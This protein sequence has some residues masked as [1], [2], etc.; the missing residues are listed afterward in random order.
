MKT[1]KEYC[2]SE[3][4]IESIGIVDGQLVFDYN[5]KADDNNISS[6]F[7]KKHSG[8]KFVPF[9][10]TTETLIRHKVYSVYYAK[11]ANKTDILK[12]IKKQKVNA[13]ASPEEYEK[14]LKR[15][16]IYL[17]S[18][19]F[20]PN[21][22]ETIIIPKSSSSLIEDVLEYVFERNTGIKF[23][24]NS[25]EKT[26]PTEIEIDRTNPKLTPEAIKY[27]EK[28]IAKAKEVGFFAMKEI[29]RVQLRRFIKNFLKLTPDK[30]LNKLL[31]GKNV[32]LVD[33]IL[34]SGNTNAE[35]IRN[36]E[37]YSPNKVISVTL[38]KT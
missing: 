24:T 1:F 12:A 29:K 22:I 30:Y 13:S 20:R 7:G 37:M 25:F 8:Q 3:A 38:F 15:T 31:D 33:D 21:G 34:A 35:M 19:I 4:L 23:A 18:K 26:A 10:S 16:A 6:T 14:F 32:A 5:T 28:E 36:L 11:G 2:S 9:S 17:D 27:L